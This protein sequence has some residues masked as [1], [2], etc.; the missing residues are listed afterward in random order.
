LH[1]AI[2]YHVSNQGLLEECHKE[3]NVAVTGGC[4]YFLFEMKTIKRFFQCHVFA[5][6]PPGRRPD[7]KYPVNIS[8][9]S[10]CVNMFH[11]QCYLV[12]T[13][14][15]IQSVRSQICLYIHIF[16]TM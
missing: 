6:S 2:I 4:C 13:V 15:R 14:I 10:R 8:H 16:F 11:S 7:D 5:Q 9:R 3:E 12:A 1:S